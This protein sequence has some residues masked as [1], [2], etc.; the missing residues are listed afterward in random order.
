MFR[1]TLLLLA[2]ACA[3]SAEPATSDR[4][5]QAI[6]QNDLPALRALLKTADVNA[7]GAQGVT[8]LMNA[9][10]FGSSDAL[11][12]LLEA[13]ADV[14]ARDDFAATPLLFG[15]SD[16]AKVKLL[17]ERGAD[18]NA[19]SKAGRTPLTL[20]ASTAGASAA[21]R[22]LLER[23]AQVNVQDGM[24]LTPLMAA[25]DAG[26]LA[27]V[28]LLLAKGAMVEGKNT[29]GMTPLMAAAGHADLEMTKLL[30]AKGA[31]VNAASPAGGIN[32]K[33]GPISLGQLTALHLAAAYAPVE[34]VETLLAA[35]AKVDPPDVRGMTPL[36]LAVASDRS[37]VRVVRLLVERGAAV[38][39]KDKAGESVLDWARKFNRAEVLDALGGGD[40]RAAA[41]RS[42]ALLQRSAGP[43][44]KEGGCASCHSHSL[45][46]VALAAARANGI[47]VSEAPAADQLQAWLMFAK[48]MQQPA[49]QRLDGP[50]GADSL[51]FPMLHLAAEK[52]PADRTTDTIAFVLAAQQRAD[53]SWHV[54][55]IARPP[56]EDGDI[57]RTAL[58]LRILQLYAPPAR[59]ADTADRV[60]RA[61]AYLRGA[62]VET[63]E[64]RTLRTLGLY[65]AGADRTTVAEG[66]RGIFTLQRADGG[67]A[68]TAS[69]ASDAYATGVTLWVLHQLGVAASAPEY[70]RAVQYLVRTQEADGS[71]HVRSRAPKFQ[72]YF[73]SGFAHGHDQWLSSAGTAWAAAGLSYA[74]GE[75]PVVRTAAGRR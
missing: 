45:P 17:V 55:G 43:F 6:R 70:R 13:G 40:V 75:A 29:M 20:A 28:Q 36:M 3:W 50:G 4:F 68:Q 62:A 39:A 35:G 31:D 56:M 44:F 19:R 12:V 26:G 46:G 63:T 9:A 42:V 69:L 10:A 24:G 14:N 57:T 11:A 53:G 49:L 52:V 41:A 15:A 16:A 61:A 72:P 67:W 2:A 51:I 25:A 47:P 1:T 30:L 73:E 7:R 5:F 32:V 37:D 60:G 58:G 18:V 64:D 22:L 74:A 48:S 34:L 38:A 71:W 23:G 21:A 65:W 59:Q 66:I 27:S 54:Q 8:P 33:N